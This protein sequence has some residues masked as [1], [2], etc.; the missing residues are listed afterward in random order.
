MRGKSEKLTPQTSRSELLQL[1]G[2]PDDIGGF[3]RK[4]KRGMI[5]KYGETE[6][7]FNGDKEDSFLFLIYR[8][9]VVNGEHYPEISILFEQ[10]ANIVT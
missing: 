9:K 1:F 2:E 7:H 8:E 5:L 3:S 4:K 10:S 6:F